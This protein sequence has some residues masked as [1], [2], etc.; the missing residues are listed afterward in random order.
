MYIH[1]IK[2]Q[3]VKY[4][5]KLVKVTE[6]KICMYTE[7]EYKAKYHAKKLLMLSSIAMPKSHTE[8]FSIFT[9]AK[10][11]CNSCANLV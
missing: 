7:I 4:P 10:T 5:K 8:R 2:Y 9:L 3:Q 11:P 1:I 6:R